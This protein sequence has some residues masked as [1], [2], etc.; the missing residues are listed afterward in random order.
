M[1]V[2]CH[3]FVV[4][5]EFLRVQVH[6]LTRRVCSSGGGSN[7]AADY[8]ASIW[9]FYAVH[10]VPLSPEDCLESVNI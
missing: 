3:R 8:L 6:L 1:L 9:L 4:A 10:P 5:A 2:R 7:S